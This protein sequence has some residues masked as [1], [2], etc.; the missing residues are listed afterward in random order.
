MASYR[1]KFVTVK[2][3][4]LGEDVWVTLKNP[5]L[6]PLSDLIPEDVPIDDQGRP[7]DM[8]QASAEAMRV[9]AGLIAEWSVL[10]PDTD[11]PLRLP[12]KADPSPL[13]RVPAAIYRAIDQEITKAFPT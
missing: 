11:E 12:T 4:D 3:D 5:K 9:R 1:D 2:F 7:L 6:R 10:D 8:K 13:E